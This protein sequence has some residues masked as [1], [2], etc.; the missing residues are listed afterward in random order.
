MMFSGV[1][2]RLYA[3]FVLVTLITALSCAVGVYLFQSL[4]TQANE[5]AQDKVPA[6]RLVL[7][8]AKES[9]RIGTLVSQLQNSSKATRHQTLIVELRQQWL[10]LQELSRQF[11]ALRGY[12]NDSNHLLL[13]RELI[14]NVVSRFDEIEQS[15]QQCIVTTNRRQAISNH[16]DQ[17][18]R[19]FLQQLHN[20]QLQF[21]QAMYSVTEGKPNLTRLKR[22]HQQHQALV[23]FTDSAQQLQQRVN[24]VPQ[25]ASA[26]LAAEQQRAREQLEA[27]QRLQVQVTG[28]AGIEAQLWVQALADAI[29]GEDAIYQARRHELAQLDA[30]SEALERH[31]EIASGMMLEADKWVQNLHNGINR[32][33]SS[34][35]RQINSYTLL[36][37]FATLVFLLLVFAVVWLYV[38]R[39]IIL[40]LIATS[41]AMNAIADGRTETSMP[42]FGEGEI[43]LMLKSLA[44]LKAYVVQVKNQAQ[45][46]GLTGLYNRRQFDETLE[47]ELRRAAR[48]QTPLSLILADID[49]FKA[50]NDNYG[51]IA[52]DSCLKAIAQLLQRQF[53]RA[54]DHCARYGGEEFAIVLPATPHDAAE[55]LAE[56]LVAQVEALKLPHQFSDTTDCVTVSAGVITL[57]PNQSHSPQLIID[58]ADKALYQAKEQ[59]RNRMIQ[60]TL[61]V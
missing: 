40:P 53:N 29:N 25:L 1:K 31:G 27:L 15:V 10:Q 11:S 23:A 28:D 22:I 17:F 21:D 14:D 24:Q 26:E 8:I 12:Q 39:G 13:R 38:G 50:Y 55:L 35:S 56:G 59:G 61:T 3:G 7:R 44:R 54:A 18:G 58:M 19:R 5:I 51:H 4:H 52:G 16:I 46:D 42:Q 49:H 36:L 33:A 9:Q 34:L 32:S 2:Q 60:N 6:M 57:V 41:Q 45:R 43:G 48:E 30:T 20:H 37:I 47:R